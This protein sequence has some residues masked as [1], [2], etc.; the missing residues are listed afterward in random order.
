M[1]K[2]LYHYKIILLASVLM[3]ALGCS[4]PGTVIDN[5]ND[6]FPTKMFG[7]NTFAMAITNGDTSWW[8]G[9]VYRMENGRLQALEKAWTAREMPQMDRENYREIFYSSS[10]FAKLAARFPDLNVEANLEVGKDITFKLELYNLKTIDM[11]GPVMLDNARKKQ[12]KESQADPL[13]QG[14]FVEALLCVDTIALRVTDRV[15][16]DLGA[17]ANIIK[18]LTVNPKVH[19][20]N[21]LKAIKLAENAIIGYIVKTPTEADFKRTIDR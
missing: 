18:K 20:D 3:P 21:N 15:Y 2:F 5:V 14:P 1:G 17:E 7:Y 9:R 16:G 10:T 8:M 19:W 4:T 11:M 12:A 13:Y 6:P